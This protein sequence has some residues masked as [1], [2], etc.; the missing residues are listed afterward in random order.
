MKK[1]KLFLVFFFF[2]MIIMLSFTV[3]A[4]RLPTIGGDD[5]AWG[6]VLNNYLNVSLN[7]SGELKNNTVSGLQIVEDTITDTDISD[8]TNLTLGEKITFTLGEVI[9]NIIN[10][11]IT[12]TGSLN[13]TQ[14][15]NVVGNTTFEG[16]LNVSGNIGTSGNVTST[17]FLGNGSQL[18]S[19]TESQIDD[20]V[21]TINGTNIN[22]LDVNASSATIHGN[23]NVTGTS[24][25]GDITITS[26]NLTTNGIVS[27]D[28][29]IT[30][31]NN[32][33]SEQVRITQDG[34]LGVG[35]TKPS[36]KLEVV[37]DVVSTGTTWTSQTSAADNN[38]RDV[39]YG[40]GLFVAVSDT[41]TTNKVMTSSD[42]IN[43]VTRVNSVS[44]QGITYSNGLFVAVA[45]NAVSTSPD[46]V[47]W[48]TRTSPADSAW[49][50]VAY[51]NGT[52]VAIAR[53]GNSKVMTSTDGITW[54][55][56]S[57]ASQ[58]NWVSI[59][60]GN[61]LFAAVS[62][63]KQAV[64]GDYGVMTSSDGISWTNQSVAKL[65]FGGITYGNGLF[66]AVA[67]SGTGNRVVTSPDG[68]TWTNRTSAADNDWMDVTY[69]N[70]LFVA[71]AETG[72]GDRIMTSP[73]G[74]NWVT[75]TS[76]ADNTWED[77]TY[78]NGVFVAVADS[79]T[80][81]R[82]MTSGKTEF[83]E[84]PH[85]NIYFGGIELRGDL[86]VTGTAYLGDI[87]ITSDN[88]TTNGI[89]SKD[90]NITFYN[91]SGSEQVRITQDG[92]L[93]IGVSNPSEKLNVSGNIGASGNV[94]STYFLGN[95]SQLTSL[96]ESQIDDLVHTINGTN[97]NVLD[98]NASS[99][100]IHGDLNVTGTTYLGDTGVG[101]TGVPS[102]PLHV[103]IPNNAIG[104]YIENS[105]GTTDKS[106]FSIYGDS[107]SL[108]IGAYDDG[109]T[110]I[111]SLINFDHDGG[112]TLPNLGSVTDVRHVCATAA[113]VLELKDGACSG[114]S[115]RFKEN[116]K[117]LAYGLDELMLLQP[118]FFNYKT[119]SN[120]T[121]DLDYLGS[122]TKRR[123]GMMAEDVFEVLPEVVVL[124]GGVIDSIDYSN[125]IPLT[126]KA[127]QEQ[128]VQID[129]LASEINLSVS[130]HT[131]PQKSKTVETVS[132]N[133]NAFG[134]AIISAEDTEVQ[135]NFETAY[136]NIPIIT[137]TPLEFIDGQYKLS[138]KSIHGFR[139]V[140]QKMQSQ[141][142][143]FDWHA[144]S[145]A[146]EIIPTISEDMVKIVTSQ[147]ETRDV[148]DEIA[149]SN[150]ENF[151]N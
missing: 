37:G 4:A 15:L 148:T 119:H 60:Y 133:T 48:T 17:Y 137:L 44:G 64:S 24:Y 81:N 5:D 117:S 130:V 115:R 84:I 63:T 95:G 86:N 65:T 105:G 66:V 36:V 73:D 33:G 131:Q 25:L 72:S 12:I 74:I 45:N 136:K 22:V 9:D 20:L 116:E 26:D 121:D 51:G 126:I 55:N 147:N 77:V 57:S 118:K 101:S 1:Q 29:N 43:W 91:N 141:E 135:I 47:I 108:S 10:G 54:T 21:H 106:E 89:V 46:G 13:V 107:Q 150:N 122:R 88:L 62:A 142:I 87:T 112:I 94:T 114:S 140:L 16:R 50:D 18:T 99:A 79:G 125:L 75:R 124:E 41:G 120:L 93:G 82:V 104:L 146:G 98:V 3:S 28:G 27:K 144:F 76:A 14:N 58:N 85:D 70:G 34:R 103:V 53:T 90:G 6:T 145:A 67:S 30:F 7:E 59:T 49:W 42:G 71:V 123:I 11:W 83:N 128:Q 61:G 151:T 69:G 97:I 56:R 23:L 143:A 109:D 31:Y 111:R 35:T 139:I 78:G 113:G 110:F 39:V 52:F 134:Q 2:V 149:H 132:F 127:I 80:G 102:G 38:W 96:T 138:E 129:S 40:N 68:V 19:L 100:T 32:S 8:M 92:R